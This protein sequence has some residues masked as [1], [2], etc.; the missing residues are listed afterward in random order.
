MEDSPFLLLHHGFCC[1]QLWKGKIKW[2]MWWLDCKGKEGR[3]EEVRMAF[4][5]FRTRT[6][7]NR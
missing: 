3:R 7:I 5:T 4:N 1:A 2:P 6:T